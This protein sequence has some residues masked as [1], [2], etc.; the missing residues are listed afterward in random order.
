MWHVRFTKKWLVDFCFSRNG[1]SCS[2]LNIFK[3]RKHSH[4]W[5]DQDLKNTVVNLTLLQQLKVIMQ[6]KLFRRC[7]HPLYCSVLSLGGNVNKRRMS[8]TDMRSI[9]PIKNQ[10]NILVI[11]N[12]YV[13]YQNYKNLMLL[14]F[15]DTK[16]T[17]M[18]LFL[19]TNSA[20]RE[21]VSICT[22]SIRN[23]NMYAEY[24]QLQY[25]RIVYATAICTQS[26]HSIVCAEYTQLQ[27]TFLAL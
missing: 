9:F 16:R 6:G 14:T 2:E 3:A 19:F 27:L 18:H 11:G 25:V 1:A 12:Y 17:L 4:Y 7:A 26:I 22:Q 24:T 5:S 21:L 23:C 10:W 8:K 15:S 13:N 20:Q